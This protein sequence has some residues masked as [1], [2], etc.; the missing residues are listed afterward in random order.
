MR[1]IYF[2]R[3]YFLQQSEKINY[4]CLPNM[5]RIIAKHNR[6]VIRGDR[7]EPPP[8][9]CQNEQCP[10]DQKCESEGVVYQATL[11]YQGD[12][13]DKYVGLTGRSF[14]D[15]HRE[16]YRNFENRNPKNATSLSRKVWQLQDRNINY[17][18]KWKN[19]QNSKPY[20][21]GSRHCY[22]NLSDSHFIIFKPQ[23]ATLNDR[24]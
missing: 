20:Q 13:V 8:C 14:K 10:V 2:L 16:H 24:N 17:E 3:D 5:K 18:V 4:S 19:L 6:K 21:P 11:S 23:E 22:L 12:R 9:N 1:P 7:N 15:R